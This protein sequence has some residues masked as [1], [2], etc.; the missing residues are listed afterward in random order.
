M[1]LI[2]GIGF[3]FSGVVE[4]DV[5]GIFA[6]LMSS[7]NLNPPAT[8]TIIIPQRI[9]LVFKVRFMGVGFFFL[10]ELYRQQGFTFFAR[11]APATRLLRV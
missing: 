3:Y 5:P 1:L 9:R 2:L 4:E 10:P 11:V 7:L 8:P 6:L